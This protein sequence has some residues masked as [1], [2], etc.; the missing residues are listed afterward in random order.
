MIF[1]KIYVG[2]KVQQG[3]FIA[4]AFHDHENDKETRNDNDDSLE[5]G[6]GDSDKQDD[7]I[8]DLFIYNAR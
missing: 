4:Y 1:K 3:I 7:D 6:I 5:D 8:S 2:S